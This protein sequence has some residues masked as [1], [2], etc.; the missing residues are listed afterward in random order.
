MDTKK[1]LQEIRSIIREE[2]DYALTKKLSEKKTKKDDISTIKHGMSI[3]NES[4]LSKKVVKPK[5]QKTEFN[6]IKELLEE[7]KRSLQESYDA[8][9]EFNFTSNMAE[10]FGY[11]RGNT[12]I[13]H[14]YSKQDIPSEVM[15]ALTKD[16]SALMKKIEEKKG[17]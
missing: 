9:D 4:Q 11:D 15:S 13:P 8:D 16:Y 7:T 3:Y 5:T 1:F 12:P 2:I 17:R 6:N 10:G 14:G